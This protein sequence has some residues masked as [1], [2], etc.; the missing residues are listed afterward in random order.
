MTSGKLLTSQDICEMTAMP[1]ELT[2]CTRSQSIA[3]LGN[4]QNSDPFHLAGSPSF[5][6]FPIRI[7]ALNRSIVLSFKPLSRKYEKQIADFQS[8][9]I[10]LLHFLK[11]DAFDYEEAGN[12]S[13]TMFFDKKDNKLVAYCST[14]CSALKIRGDK[15][16]SLC[17]SV[18]IAVLCV[19][20]RY[21][22]MGIG[23]AIIKHILQEVYKIR[24]IAGVQFVTLF[25]LEEAV[26]FYEK[27][28]FRKLEKDMKILFA[29]VHKK[30]V[31]MYFTL[32]HSHLGKR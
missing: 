10:Q 25:A 23:Q 29:P 21:R 16:F 11:T 3:F 32:P 27:L 31:P 5:L 30:C 20:D 7:D 14:K 22:Y 9:N 8:A 1:G 19:D 6:S 12:T 13:T 28:D 2:E 15:I 4:I 24:K 17:P 26:E 18:E